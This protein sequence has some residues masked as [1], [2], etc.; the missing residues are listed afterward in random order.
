WSVTGVQTCALPI[1]DFQR[2]SRK[3]KVQSYTGETIVGLDW[4]PE[5]RIAFCDDRVNCIR[6]RVKDVDG[7]YVV[8]SIRTFDA[9]GVPHVNAR[10]EERRVG[11]DGR[12]R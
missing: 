5:P 7:R 11:K 12:A 3:V 1:Y 10:S 4:L 2:P 6:V 8:T 9:D